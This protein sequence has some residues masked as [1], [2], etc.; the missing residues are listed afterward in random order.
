MSEA[1]RSRHFSGEFGVVGRD[2]HAV[3]RLGKVKRRALFDVQSDSHLLRQD[4][5]K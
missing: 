4:R 3:R 2:P 5:A 1:I